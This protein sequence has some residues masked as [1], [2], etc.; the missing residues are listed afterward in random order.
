MNILLKRNLSGK[1]M[2]SNLVLSDMIQGTYSH[3][4]LFLSVLC[5]LSL[6]YSYRASRSDVERYP[7][8][9]MCNLCRT[10]VS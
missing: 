4:D 10:I 5:L 7:I 3:S 8:V 2:E 1:L 9:S 6:K